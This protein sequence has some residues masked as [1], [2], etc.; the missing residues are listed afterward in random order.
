MIVHAFFTNAAKSLDNL[1][2]SRKRSAAARSSGCG[3]EMV[4]GSV[5]IASFRCDR[6]GFGFDQRPLEFPPRHTTAAEHFKDVAGVL[7][8]LLRADRLHVDRDVP[9][10]R[11]DLAG[12]LGLEFND[13]KSLVDGSQ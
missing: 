1:S 4:F 12:E 3:P 8:R 11:V 9:L 10:R 13:S 6:I 2:A 5:C 7:D